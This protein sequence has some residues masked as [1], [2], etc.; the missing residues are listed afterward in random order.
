MSR[1]WIYLERTL[2]VQGC[3]ILVFVVAVLTHVALG[4]T[5][6]AGV[7]IAMACALGLWW[8]VFSQFNLNRQSH[9]GDKEGG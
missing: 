7:W 1:L 2:I 8:G 9:T 4:H 6:P 5:L 3:A